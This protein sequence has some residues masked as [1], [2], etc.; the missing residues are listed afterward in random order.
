MEKEIK[1]RIKMPNNF[2]GEKCIIQ[3]T[4][5]KSKK[6]FWYMLYLEHTVYIFMDQHIDVARVQILVADFW[7][8]GVFN[9]KSEMD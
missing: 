2:Y 4:R 9:T 6:M 8:V 5:F 7:N 1:T 3:Q